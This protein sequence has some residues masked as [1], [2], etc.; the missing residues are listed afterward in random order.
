[1]EGQSE[2]RNSSV[3]VLRTRLRSIGH[4]IPWN[5]IEYYG[6]SGNVR[7][8]DGIIVPPSE[9]SSSCQHT[10]IKPNNPRNPEP[11]RQYERTP[12]HQSMHTCRFQHPICGPSQPQFAKRFSKA[13]NTPPFL[14]IPNRIQ[15]LRPGDITLAPRLHLSVYT[16]SQK[17]NFSSQS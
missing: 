15:I 10:I 12:Y 6:T 17:V 7:R 16:V 8:H 13:F 4:G 9:Y 11:P 2:R 14:Y 1:M 3:I 5:A